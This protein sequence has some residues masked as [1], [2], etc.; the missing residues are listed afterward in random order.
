M[1]KTNSL[2]YL[3]YSANVRPAS[4][5]IEQRCNYYNDYEALINDKQ[6][7]SKL[8]MFSNFQDGEAHFVNGRLEP[9]K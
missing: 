6:K 2:Y 7:L 3:S 8:P 9:K 5:Y 4:Y 1:N